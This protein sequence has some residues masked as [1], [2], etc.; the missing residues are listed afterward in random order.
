MI[1]VVPENDVVIPP[2][3]VAGVEALCTDA[4]GPPATL[5]ATGAMVVALGPGATGVAIP[6]ASDTGHTVVERAIVEV[7]TTG[8][9]EAAGQSLTEEGHCVI[10]PTDVV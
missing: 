10:V 1:G 2:V 4:V 9:F 7:T 6:P 8:V 3:G 5:L